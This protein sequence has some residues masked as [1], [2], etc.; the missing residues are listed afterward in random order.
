MKKWVSRENNLNLITSSSKEKVANEA[1]SQ[2]TLKQ[3]RFRNE[4]RI[5]CLCFIGRVSTRFNN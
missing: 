1:L 4:K 3:I 5:A 2:K